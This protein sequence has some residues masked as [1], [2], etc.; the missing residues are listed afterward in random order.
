MRFVDMGEFACVEPPGPCSDDADL[1][2]VDAAYPTAEDWRDSVLSGD[3][4]RPIDT[5]GA[6]PSSAVGEVTAA[7][8]ALDSR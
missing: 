3:A 7:A 6:A 4:L 8:A 2:A 5:R 1:L